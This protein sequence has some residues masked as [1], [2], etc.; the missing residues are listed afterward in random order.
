MCSVGDKTYNLSRVLELMTQ[1]VTKNEPKLICLPECCAFIGNTSTDVLSASE[2]LFDENGMLSSNFI[3]EIAKFAANNNVYVSVGGFP[4]KIKDEQK[5]HNSHIFIERDGKVHPEN[6][7][8]K[9]HLFDNPLT[10]LQESK[11]T[12]AGNHLVTVSLHDFN[13]KIGLSTCY[14][15]RFPELYR[16]LCQP[17]DNIK[18]H[19][20][21]EVVGIDAYISRSLEIASLDYG[22]DV[23]LIPSAFTVTTGR[24]H[25]ETLLRA[26]AIEN[27]VYVIAAAQCGK[28]NDTRESYGHSMAIDPWGEIL[29]HA[30]S[31]TSKEAIL[32]VTI[33][34]KCLQHVRQNMP[35]WVSHI[36]DFKF[37]FNIALM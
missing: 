26:R 1:A 14:D 9:L 12:K 22:A 25:W 16:A 7:Y 24:A 6:V 21:N 17:T 36:S 8:R 28:H 19:D 31:T 37:L 4:E 32:Y 29:A 2:I 30:D 3:S 11:S 27:Q 13:I 33:D 10:G 20:L 18:L 23:I 34:R 5:I 15:V 35:V